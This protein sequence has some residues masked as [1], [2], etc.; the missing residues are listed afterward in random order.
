[1]RTRHNTYPG[2]LAWIIFFLLYKV[3]R[4][5]YTEVIQNLSRSFPEKSYGEIKRIATD[6]YRHFSRL[7]VEIPLLMTM[8]R[9]QASR[10]LVLHNAALIE[11]Y[12]AQGRP[13]IMMLGH[14]GNWECMSL[15]PALW[16]YPVYAVFK[17]LR[18]RFFDRLMQKIRSRFG[19]RLLAMEDA[20]RHLLQ[21]KPPPGVYIFIADQSPPQRK[22]VVDFLHQPTPVITGTERLAKAVDAV[23][24][25]A[26]IHKKG[27]QWEMS[28][29]LITDKAATAAPFE[30]TRIF[31]TRLEKDIC[32]CPA[33]WLWTHRRWKKNLRS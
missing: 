12:L 32:Q 31:N 4:Y 11:Q 20:P 24:V 25:Y 29:S 3:M 14:Y 22:H 27:G 26:V 18:N 8:P 21:R 15:L 19:L 33:Y 2:G 30:I 10:R 5:R 9:K 13:V 7:F 23:V 1:M 16:H 6:F 28:F 17:P